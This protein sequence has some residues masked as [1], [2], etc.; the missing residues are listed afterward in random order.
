MKNLK[1]LKEFNKDVDK[2]F[3]ELAI[4]KLKKKKLDNYFSD[5][6]DMKTNMKKLNM[7][8]YD[9]KKRVKEDISEFERILDDNEYLEYEYRYNED[10]LI[11]YNRIK[12]LLFNSYK[13]NTEAFIFYM[14][15]VYPEFNANENTKLYDLEDVLRITYPIIQ[16]EKNRLNRVHIPTNLPRFL[17]NLGLGKKLYYYALDKVN[18]ISSINIDRS[19]EAE[20]VWDSIMDD[21]DVYSFINDSKIIAFKSDLEF[22]YIKDILE[23]KFYDINIKDNNYSQCIIDDDFK[24]KYSKEIENCFFKNLE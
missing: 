4:S 12:I 24:E 9:I 17:K 20:L 6:S 16:I 22:D 10:I 15:I 7:L 23:T 21:K 3:E 13:E 8:L 19:K 14:N 2:I 5:I 11:E 18:Y 1:S